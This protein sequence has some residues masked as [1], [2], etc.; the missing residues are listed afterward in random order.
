MV[1]FKELKL[2]NDKEM[3]F[4]DCSVKQYNI[5]KDIYISGIWIDYYR[6]VKTVGVPSNKAIK[7]FES[8]TDEMLKSVQAS[9]KISQLTED[10]G[11]SD[12]NEGMFYVIVKCAGT[13]SSSVS[14]LP[15]GYDED[16]DV[17][18]IFDMSMLYQMG[19]NIVAYLQSGDNNTC[20]DYY[21]LDNY[22]A[23]WE[24]LRIASDVCDYKLVET[25][26]DKLIKFNYN[27]HEVICSCRR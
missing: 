22:I 24:S 8:K 14:K 20:D 5:Y 11:T 3:L 6:N 25:L 9:L 18:V 13:L 23:L 27:S 1:E 2:S 21:L 15:C 17:A 4:V 7:I 12:F 19:M 16:T 10:F 26:W